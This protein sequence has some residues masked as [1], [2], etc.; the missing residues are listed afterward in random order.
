MNSTDTKRTFLKNLIKN[1]MVTLCKILGLRVLQELRKDLWEPEPSSASDHSAQHD[2][3]S[4][5]NNWEIIKGKVNLQECWVFS[6]KQAYLTGDVYLES[7][8][9]LEALGSGFIK[10][11]CGFL[12][13]RDQR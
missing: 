13:E 9:H 6:P 7:S 5:H 3:S 10:S 12:K 2:G 8:K 11:P 4:S 1:T